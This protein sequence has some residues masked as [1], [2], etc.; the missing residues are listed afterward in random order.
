MKKKSLVAL[1]VLASLAVGAGAANAGHKTF[2]DGADLPDF[3]KEYDVNED[4]VIDE[5]EKQAVKA[6]RKEARATRRAEIDTNGDNAISDEERA[7]AREAVL[8][9]IEA[10]RAEKFAEI[11]G[12]DGAI[13]AVEFAAIPALEGKNADRVVALFGRLDSDDSE[14]VSLEEFNARLTNHRGGMRGRRPSHGHGPRG[15]T[16][17]DP[18]GGGDPS[19]E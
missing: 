8:A 13:S 10:K 2:G 6:A 19:V 9:K 11:A 15:G 16:N 17:D 12:D 1:S 5:E 7:A 18:N 4:G 14:S 3:L